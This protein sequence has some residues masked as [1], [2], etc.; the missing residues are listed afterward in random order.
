MAIPDMLNTCLSYLIAIP[1]ISR[2]NFNEL[3]I[4][5]VFI[6]LPPS[7]TAFEFSAPFVNSIEDPN[8]VF[9]QILF[10]ALT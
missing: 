2:S 4:V 7:F 3:T 1:L 5:F 8:K 9:C 10:L 6:V